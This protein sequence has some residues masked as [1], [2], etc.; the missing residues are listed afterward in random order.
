M[1][2]ERI[3]RALPATLLLA[4]GLALRLWFIFKH[5]LVSGD[6]LLYADI[7][8]NWFDHHIYG[9]TTDSGI[10]PTLIRLP[11]YPLF[12]GICFVFFG[13][14]H[15]NAVLIVQA[16]FELVGCVLI[17]LL[18]HNLFGARA[19]II[20][21]ALG[22]LCPFTANYTATPLAETLTLFTISLALF[23]LERWQTA[24]YSNGKALNAH[25][26]LIAV[27]VGYGILLRPDEALLAV[28]V[29]PAM[30]WIS[31]KHRHSL[32][33]TQTSTGT[34]AVIITLLPACLCMA[35]ALS[36][37]VPWTIRNAHTMHVFQPL[38]PRYASDPGEAI[39]SGF[40]RWFRTWGVEF[41]DT[42]SA[43]WNYP[44]DP[45]NIADLPNR[46]FDSQEQYT[47][48]AEIINDANQHTD[49]SPEIE[50]RF[51][52][53]AKER[54]A[55]DPLR[56]W[57]ELPIARVA[58]MLLR[59]RTENM[60]IDLRWWQYRE[61]RADTIFS[62]AY[63]ALNLAYIVAGIFGFR[64]AW[65]DS[66]S[67]TRSP[68]RSSTRIILATGA[69]YILLRCAMLLTIDNSEPRYTLEFFPILTLFAAALFARND[70]RS[71]R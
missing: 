3:R 54:I 19:G 22:C 35:L 52:A 30:L 63:A 18:A 60:A 17:A 1:N 34:H 64:R 28:A 41:A 31:Y 10:Q 29:F 66:S 69:A 53:L 2:H 47:H 68:T 8:K 36:P 62:A 38:A 37:L 61:H 45:I 26:Y 49:L 51:A 27:A 9:H 56:Y 42:S 67:P 55:E 5:S 33:T 21:L 44:D 6:T 14:D 13:T 46:A 40:Y 24:L 70:H 65:R 20:A 57:I 23:S 15:F 50:D 32:A 58:N 11:G 39:P 16:L 25:L 4:A 48:T 12:L 59:P 7:A 43:Y 71:H